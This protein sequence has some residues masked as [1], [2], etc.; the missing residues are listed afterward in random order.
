[1]MTEEMT[2]QDV[3]AHMDQADADKKSKGKTRKTK[4][5]EVTSDFDLE[6]EWSNIEA[7][8]ESGEIFTAEIS[9]AVKGG[10]IVQLNGIRAFVPA[11][12]ISTSYVE[13]LSIYKGKT[14]EF[15]VIEIDREKNRVILSHKVVLKMKEV[16][17]T[18]EALTSLE[19]G[20]IVE[21]EVVRLT[22]FG[23]FVKV[24]KVEGLVH[25][26]EISHNRVKTS[27]DALSVG[28]KVQVKVLNVDADANRLSLSIKATQKGPWELA[29]DKLFVGA[30]LEGTVKRLTNFGAFVEVFPGVEGL[31]H[32]SQISHEHIKAPYEVISE[33]E[34]VKVKVIGYDFD[35]KRLSLSMKALI[36]NPVEEVEDFELPEAST[37]FSLGDLFD[38]EL[39]KK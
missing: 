19:V 13:D 24:G 34:Q 38:N 2:M 21:G 37:G 20:T 16:A 33:N 27:A 6:Q 12:M 11:S 36:E 30:V 18:K 22:N 17:E 3:L 4:E 25:L 26:S 7:K 15:K 5:A 14:L 28:E 9:D 31:T 32:V 35:S 8:L 39:N 29:K 10:L 1:M 23:A